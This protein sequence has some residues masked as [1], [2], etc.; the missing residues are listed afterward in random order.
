M[1][2]KSFSAV[3]LVSML[4]LVLASTAGARSN[5]FF[6]PIH[7][8]YPAPVGQAYFFPQNADV[9]SRWY[10]NTPW[11]KMFYRLW[12][13]QFLFTFQGHN[14]T[15]RQN[16]TLIYNGNPEGSGQ[17]IC[18]GTAKSDRHGNLGFTASI[19]TCSLPLPGDVNPRIMLVPSNA[20]NCDEGTF[21]ADAADVLVSFQTVQYF[22]TD[23]CPGAVDNGDDPEQPPAGPED[24]DNGDTGSDTGGTT[25]DIPY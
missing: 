22:D 8:Y 25:T 7:H 6:K 14:L 4:F 24:E 23:G 9:Q 16:F 11:G 5:R 3:A 1:L 18:L 2:R 21:S 13:K 20:V 12:S 15:P 17:M 19:E 10:R